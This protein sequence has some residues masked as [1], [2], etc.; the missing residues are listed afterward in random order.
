[1]LRISISGL[2]SNRY[3]T[4][5]QPVSEK[6][7]QHRTPSHPPYLGPQFERPATWYGAKRKVGDAGLET[8]GKYLQERLVKLNNI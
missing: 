7:K 5:Y 1:M 2:S 4:F 6:A 8:T 3:H